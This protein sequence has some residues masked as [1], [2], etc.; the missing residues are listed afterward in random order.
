MDKQLEFSEKT[1]RN[2]LFGQLS[3]QPSGRFSTFF[4]QYLVLIKIKRTPKKVN[5]TNKIKCLYFIIYGRQET[6][7]SKTD[8]NEHWTD[9]NEHSDRDEIHRPMRMQ[10]SHNVDKDVRFDPRLDPSV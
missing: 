8:R 4:H 5:Q 6:H 2:H 10:H 7:I 9:R 1:A 3:Q